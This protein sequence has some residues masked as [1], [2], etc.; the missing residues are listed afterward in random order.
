MTSA[1][2][3]AAAAPQPG[4]IAPVK[5]EITPSSVSSQVMTELK[6]VRNHERTI[7]NFGR[8]LVSFGTAV[9][10]VGAIVAIAAFLVSSPVG[11][12]VGGAVVV[13]GLALG[14]TGIVMHVLQSRH[15][16]ISHLQSVKNGFMGAVK[17][18]S[19]VFSSGVEADSL[20]K[21]HEEGT[22]SAKN[23]GSWLMSLLLF[24]ETKGTFGKLSFSRSK[25]KEYVKYTFREDD[26]SLFYLRIAPDELKNSQKNETFIQKRVA[27][28]NK[29]IGSEP[30]AYDKI[31][32]PLVK[33]GKISDACDALWALYKN[34]ENDLIRKTDYA[35]DIA[36]L[37][38]RAGKK[39]VSKKY[40]DENINGTILEMV[41]M[42]N[43]VEK[44]DPNDLD[45]R[46]LIAINQLKKP[47]PLQ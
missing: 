2:S 19:T 39:P 17:A 36:A 8:F 30:E 22:P 46:L 21:G 25:E 35:I 32:A 42:V 9:A 11:W 45:P 20:K 43:E 34:E 10:V 12:A 29:I 33:S 18:I 40:Y 37:M 47:K 23:P 31:V 4:E 7:K 28:G 41:K 44:Q 38:L 14:I 26:K 5:H 1:V 15:K 16:P 3:P 6:S 13:L 27:E 24:G